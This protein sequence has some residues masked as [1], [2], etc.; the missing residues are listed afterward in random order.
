[1]NI[2]AL[3]PL[4]AFVGAFCFGLFVY[5]QNPKSLA[6]KSFAVLALLAGL[7]SFVEFGY[8][9]SRSPGEDLFWRRAHNF[10]P[11]VSVLLIYFFLVFSSKR[12]LQ[13][14]ILHYPLAALLLAVAVISTYHAFNAPLHPTEHRLG[15]IQGNLTSLPFSSASSLF[16][17]FTWAGT[18]LAMV[19][20]FTREKWHTHRIQTRF[21]FGGFL[22]S[23]LFL[24]Y[25]LLCQVSRRQGLDINW[26]PLPIGFIIV[27]I[28]GTVSFALWRQGRIALV[29]ISVADRIVS[30]MD[31]MLLL[32]NPD[33]TIASF[34][35]VAPRMLKYPPEALD[36]MPVIKL[37]EK[38]G[39]P[40]WL[41][42]ET[43]TRSSAPKYLDTYVS[44]QAGRRIPVSLYSAVLLNDKKHL[45]GYLL[46]ARD[47]E[48]RK[49]TEQEL[50]VYKNRLE[51]LVQKRSEELTA[52]IER[53][54][55]QINERVKAEEKREFL[56]EERASL[57]EQL[58]HAQK[59][60]SIGRLAG[61]V[62]HD[63]N[64]LLFVINTYS[65]SFLKTMTENHPLFS[66]FQE[67]YHAA[68]RATSLTQQ[69]LAFSK[70]QIASPKLINPNKAIADLTKMIRRIIGD[71]VTLEVVPLEDSG[72]IAIDPG[73]F[74][75]M[76]VNLA[77][78]ARDAMPDGGRIVIEVKR[79]D[80]S[81]V[82]RLERM[83][84]PSADYLSIAFSD[85]GIGM[86]EETLAKIFDPFFTTKAPGKG[87]GLGL[88]MIYGIVKQNHGVLEVSSKVDE[89][90]TFTFYFPRHEPLLDIESEAMDFITHR[91]EETILLVE[92]E[93]QVRKLA[94]RLL[95]QLGYHVIEASG[96]GEAMLAIHER[97]C[98]VDLLFTDIVMPGVS[99]RQLSNMLH[100]AYPTLKVLYM[101]G[102]HEEIESSMVRAPEE[103]PFLAKPFSFRELSSKIREILDN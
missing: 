90:T 9:Q 43:A 41:E 1:M 74:D 13:N 46:I 14:R 42:D 89:G 2:L 29:P 87:T 71:D 66:D 10:W 34:N 40:E 57:E 25:T 70:K 39:A 81:V 36:R 4:V 63:F 21:F 98:D 32:V 8:L 97:H 12:V 67:I 86:D 85:E 50:Q 80:V 92:D 68:T 20:L 60:E 96:A 103:A 11:L 59:M 88:S 19:P 3:P 91:G 56:K 99:G 77:V 53:L 24:F 84:S 79:A 22:V 95:E 82:E 72:R 64:N 52:S 5:F 7:L 65:E 45:L 16:F 6:N 49:R 38:G 17:Y 31:D 28:L 55:G 26:L 83:D 61:G 73:Q 30:A 23:V 100:Q 69:L 33:K 15:W 54:K 93:P 27:I 76:L 62:A 44:T 58:F 78:N 35:D 48:E 75:Q 18:C 101:S 102:Y 37:F 94:A 51:Q 47:I